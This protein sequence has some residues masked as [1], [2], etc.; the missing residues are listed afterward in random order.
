MSMKLT[1]TSKTIALAITF[2]LVWLSLV[3]TANSGLYWLGPIIGILAYAMIL[4]KLHKAK[5]ATPLFWTALVGFGFDLLV[6]NLGI[7][8]LH[9]NNFS[10]SWLLILGLVF[11]SV[12][13]QLFSWLT[14]L[15]TVSSFFLGA[16]GGLVAYFGAK[17]LGAVVINDLPAFIALYG[18]FWGASFSI[19]AKIFVARKLTSSRRSTE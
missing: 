6:H 16:L 17:T 5:M 9:S 4:P 3:A 12:F 2:N 1:T 10:F 11:V 19:A 18:I 14:I 13:Y 15:N 8:T 7:I